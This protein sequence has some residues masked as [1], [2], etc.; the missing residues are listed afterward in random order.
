MA[1]ITDKNKASPDEVFAEL[2]RVYE[3]NDRNRVKFDALKAELERMRR[4]KD[5]AMRMA[6]AAGRGRSREEENLAAIFDKA[7]EILDK[8]KQ[9]N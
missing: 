2:Q 5:F 3:I 9:E 4:E 8:K 1:R 6:A 7:V